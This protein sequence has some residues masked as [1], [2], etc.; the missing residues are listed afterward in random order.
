MLVFYPMR[1]QDCKR[2]RDQLSPHRPR[3]LYVHVPLCRAKCRYCDFYSLPD[4][5]DLVDAYVRAAATELL[6][7]QG[8]LTCPLTSVYVGGGTPT[9]LGPVALADLLG[10]ITP[11]VD[12]DT[13]FSVEANPESVAPAVA[14]VLADAGVNRVTIGVQSFQPRLLA[15]LG[16]SHTATQAVNAVRI[17]REAGIANIGI[18][19][20]YGIPGQT[21]GTWQQTLSQ[22]LDLGIQHLSCYALSFEPGTELHEARQRGDLAEMDEG[23]QRDLYDQAADAAARGRMQ[24]YEISNFALPARRSRHNLT[25]WLN[26]PYVGIGPAAA[27]YVG[28]VRSTASAD[29]EAYLASPADYETRCAS[30][31]RLTGRA[32]MAETAMLALRLT[33]GIDRKTFIARFGR[34]A[35]EVF[36]QPIERYARQG[37]LIVTDAHIRLARSAYF[38]SDTILA[39][40][41]ADG[42]HA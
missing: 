28:G 35:A 6:A 21:P 13:E 15:F 12:A 25:Y 41:I 17:L 40:I 7:R 18:D 9:V 3:A 37:A 4:R 1:K 33:Q 11:C 32:E 30:S 42:A 10:S 38:V 2:K 16:R 14:H 8:E 39:D 23:V 5:T 26:E 34:D 24:H 29:L 31:E 20:I 22:A 27:S 19:L 36:A